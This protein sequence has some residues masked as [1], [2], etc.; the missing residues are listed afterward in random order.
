MTRAE[1]NYLKAMY[2]L[3]AGKNQRV[4]TTA[5]AER[6]ETKPS[7]ATDMLQKLHDK[8]MVKYTRYK[9][10]QLSP[11]GRHIASQIVRKHRL[12]E[13]F[14]VEKLA[15][16][17]DQVHDIAEQL[18][19][20]KSPDL[21]ERLDVFLGCPKVDPHGD[22]IPDDK[23]NIEQINKILLCEQEPNSRCVL[24]G[25]KDTDDAF[26]KYLSQ[27]NIKLG[28]LI[29]V[30]DKEPFDESMTVV[31]DQKTHFISKIISTNIYVQPR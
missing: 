19:H 3:S 2:Q 17:W 8:S 10:A 20:I 27:K 14:L 26:L 28:S 11:E 12:W 24:M 30:L 31:I 29:T 7:S 18:E 22:P 1:E 15:F 25:I 9:G 13:V 16:G 5:L 6:L 4:S 21:V 23:G